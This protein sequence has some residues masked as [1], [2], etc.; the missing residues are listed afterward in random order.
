MVN[1]EGWMVQRRHFSHFLHFIYFV[2]I[3]AEVIHGLFDKVSRHGKG[4]GAEL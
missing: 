1:G 3:G 2:M 4:L